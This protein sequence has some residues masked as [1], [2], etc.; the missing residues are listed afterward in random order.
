MNDLQPGTVLSIISASSEPVEH[1]SL[2]LVENASIVA[3]TV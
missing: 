1:A 3:G 2:R